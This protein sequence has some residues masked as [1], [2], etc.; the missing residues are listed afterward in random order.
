MNA[1]FYFAVF[2]INAYFLIPIFD[3][4]LV[5][6]SNYQNLKTK[7]ESSAL[8][9]DFRQLMFNSWLLP[10]NQKRK[11]KLSAFNSGLTRSSDLCII[12]K[13]RNF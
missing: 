8:F 10:L 7:N 12:L 4:F 5:K 6:S 3:C 1:I 11:H 9:I 13:Q 2:R